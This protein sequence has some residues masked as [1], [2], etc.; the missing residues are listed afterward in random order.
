MAGDE[1]EEALVDA[2]ELLGAEVAVVDGATRPTFSRL[3]DAE[4]ADGG[5]QG[6]VGQ[7]QAGDDVDGPDLEEAAEAGQAQLGSAVVAEAVEDERERLP[8][9]GVAGAAA[10]SGEWRSRAVENQSL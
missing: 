9:V 6:V 4:V 8:E 7:G 2:A 3:D 5:E 10:A 1:L